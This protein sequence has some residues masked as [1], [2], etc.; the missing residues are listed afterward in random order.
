MH[1]PALAVEL[2]T[3]GSSGHQAALSIYADLLQGCLVDSVQGDRT[4]FGERIGTAACLA[5]A[6]DHVAAAPSAFG[7]RALPLVDA[8]IAA[9]RI[10]RYVLRMRLKDPRVCL[11]D[12]P[13]GSGGC[14]GLS[15]KD[16]W[17]DA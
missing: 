17:Q 16:V 6:E 12:A 1:P 8:P 5:L 7:F 2:S 4:G 14:L 9:W 3:E 13:G 10:R 15:L 11:G